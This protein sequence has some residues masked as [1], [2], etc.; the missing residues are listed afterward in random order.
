M[1][2]DK[3]PGTLTYVKLARVCI[4]CLRQEEN[5]AARGNAT[6]ILMDMATSLDQEIRMNLDT[7]KDEGPTDDPS[8]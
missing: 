5:V 6:D 4:T 2:L 1:S 7:V 3:L 8:F